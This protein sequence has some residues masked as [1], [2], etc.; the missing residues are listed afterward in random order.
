MDQ[1]DT[2][3]TNGHDEGASGTETNGD[4]ELNPKKF[5]SGS[6]TQPEKPQNDILN[7]D[8]NRTPPRTPTKSMP[9]AV[10][11]S[12]P[13]FVAIEEVM[14]AANG[15]SNMYLAHEIAVNQDFKLEKVQAPQGGLRTQVEQVMKKAF[16]DIL[17]SQLNESPSKFK[18]A[19]VLLAEIKQDLSSLL[20]PQHTKLKQEIEEILDID[21]IKQQAENGALDFQRYAQYVL[22]VMARL[23]APVRDERIRELTQTSEVVPLFRGIMELLEVMKLDMANFTIQQMRPHIQQQSIDYERKKF[24]EFLETQSKLSNGLDGLE[25]TKRWLERNY[26]SIDLSSETN[27]KN[28]TNKVLLTA[29]IELLVWDDTKQ[30]L[31]PETLLMDEDRFTALRNDVTL[32]TL[33]GSTLLL[34]FAATGPSVQQLSDFKKTLKEHLMLILGDKEADESAKIENASVQVV[35]D[36]KRC[37]EEHNMPLLDSAKE[38]TLEAQI[39]DLRNKE[40]RVRKIIERR[41]LEFV[42]TVASSNTAAP[43]QIP[44]GLSV[45]QDELS[46][47]TGSYMRLVSHNRAVFSEFYADIIQRISSAQAANY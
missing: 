14:K 47:L 43:V 28:I 46:A 17:E 44:A 13:K 42:E 22:S 36:L 31:Y 34:A 7:H 1:S 6:G 40:N 38:A 20:L 8:A 29:F 32:Y 27:E 23:C 9:F 24:Q 35:Q 21:L 3:S 25:Y 19:L 37:L 26:E 4:T 41:V 30:E 11:A 39:K 5:A 2:V 10:A 33:V 12:P 18:Q 15:M 45:L 16:W